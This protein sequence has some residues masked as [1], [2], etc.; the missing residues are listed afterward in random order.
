MSASRVVRKSSI[1][2][3]G[4]DW[5]K[6]R[7]EWPWLYESYAVLGPE[8]WS[9]LRIDVHGRVAK[10][11]ID[12]SDTPS[13]VVNGLKGEELRGGVALWG[14]AGEEAY[15]ANFKVTP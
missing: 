6:L 15:F 3:P 10:L 1:S 4:F 9:H 13:L 7:R 11:F 2:I 5:Y 12:R 14:Y 8:H